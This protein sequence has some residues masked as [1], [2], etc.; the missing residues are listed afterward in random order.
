MATTVGPRFDA[1]VADVDGLNPK[2]IVTARAGHDGTD[3]TLAGPPVWFANKVHVRLAASYQYQNAG[4]SDGHPVVKFINNSRGQV[5]SYLW[6]FGD[7]TFSVDKDPQHAFLNGNP[8]TVKL[9]L[10]KFDDTQVVY[11]A[12]VTA[13]GTTSSTLFGPAPPA[14]TYEIDPVPAFKEF[15]L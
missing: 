13:T 15:G 12:S 2:E 3:G 11:S 8:H 7:T 14:W 9:T 6:D 1:K 10:T 5:K 4:L